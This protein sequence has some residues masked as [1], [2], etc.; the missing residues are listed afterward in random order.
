MLPIEDDPCEP[1]EGTGTGTGTGIGIVIGF[2]LDKC[3]FDA[4][5]VE[6][7]GISVGDSVD[8]SSDWGGGKTGTTTLPVS[9]V[10][11]KKVIET[12]WVGGWKVMPSDALVSKV[13]AKVDD[14]K[15][16]DATGTEGLTADDV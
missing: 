2:P 9:V 5:V 15:D 10:L 4:G 3:G 11:E 14:A 16:N 6:P 13:D 12:L 8:M 1:H 7:E